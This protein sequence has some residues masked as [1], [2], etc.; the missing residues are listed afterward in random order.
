MSVQVL[1]LL[2]DALSLV[3]ANAADEPGTNSDVQ[4]ALRVCNSMLGRWSAQRLL[5]RSTTTIQFALT[6]GKRFYTVAPSGADVVS[7]KPS[8]IFSA[9]YTQVGQ[10][11][12]PLD[13]I[14]REEYD[15]L[16]DA[17]MSSGP[18]MYVMYDPGSSQ[19]TTQT[20]TIYIY[21]I[22]DSAYTLHLEAD[23]PL[24]QFIN[25][26]DTVTFEDAYLEPII[27]NLAVRLWR[28]F[29]PGKETVPIDIEGIAVSG[30]NVLRTLNAVRI[31]ASCDLPGSSGGVYNIF[32]DQV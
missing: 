2:M 31:Q 6:P 19:Q 4:L 30:M 3:G 29:H 5:L 27:Y 14:T 21:L 20:G 7:V 22:P 25:V 12:T 16:G 28:H 24:T 1:S 23:T 11:D 10:I 32:T 13:I 9:Y 15:N 18:P 26:L 17:L 8:R